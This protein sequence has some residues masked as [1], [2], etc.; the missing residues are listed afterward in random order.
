M[1]DIDCKKYA[2]CLNTAAK[3]DIKLDC[4]KCKSHEAAVVLGHLGGLK[5]GP[6][7]A[8]SLSKEERVRIARKAAEVRWEKEKII[9]FDCPFCHSTNLDFEKNLYEIGD[10]SVICINKECGVLGPIGKDKEEAIKK[11]NGQKLVGD[12][13]GR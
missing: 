5:G 10:F 3:S 4:Q 2:E 7:R 8:K 13:E 6:A 1:R 11:W 12:E 9:I